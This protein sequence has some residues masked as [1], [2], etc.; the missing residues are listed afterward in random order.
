MFTTAKSISE[1]LKE[2]KRI[3]QPAPHAPPSPP[4]PAK[5]IV[6]FPPTQLY[7]E[8]FIMTW[9]QAITHRDCKAVVSCLSLQRLWPPQF[10]FLAARLVDLSLKGPWSK[11]KRFIQ[12]HANWMLFIV[13][14]TST[15]HPHLPYPICCQS[16]QFWHIFNASIY[17]K[18]LSLSPKFMNFF[19]AVN[20]STSD[21]PAIKDWK[22][23]VNSTFTSNFWKNT[24]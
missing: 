6:N 1:N 5:F 15:N 2:K 18:L 13:W 21:P 16:P 19:S 24:Q 11:C 23:R 8:S 17:F 4:S 12:E 3:S 22:V 20:P 10:P 7:H 9:V 14:K